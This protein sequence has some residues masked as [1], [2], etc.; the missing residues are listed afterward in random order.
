MA[1]GTV[2]GAADAEDGP[3]PETLLHQYEQICESLRSIDDFRAKL[4]A[5]WPILGGAAG[6][7][8][9]LLARDDADGLW[10]IAIFG[11]WAS[12]GL[13]VYEWH[14]SLH[15]ALLKSTA[16]ELERQ[17]H[18]QVGTGQFLS[19]PDGFGLQLQRGSRGAT[20]SPSGGYPLIRVGVASVIVYGAVILGWLGL[21]IYTLVQ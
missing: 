7:V 15:C 3:C 12:I 17:L 13:G 16:R 19:V 4:L 6:G 20:A 2:S 9:L 18:L 14:Q 21:L 1:D 11:L 8:A 10:A 5:L